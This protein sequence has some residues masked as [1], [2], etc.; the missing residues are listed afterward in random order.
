MQIKISMIYL[1]TTI[2]M[3]KIEKFDHDLG[4]W[5]CEATEILMNCW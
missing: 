3:S 4:R 5:N 2:Q 1:Y